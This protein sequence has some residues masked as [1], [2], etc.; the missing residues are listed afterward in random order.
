MNKGANTKGMT[1]LFSI[2]YAVL[3]LVS[4]ALLFSLN[5]TYIGIKPDILL[6]M[7]VVC[8]LFCTNKVSVALALVFGLLS[9]LSVTPP[10]HFSPVLFVLCAFFVPRLASVFSK[11]GTTEAAVCAIPFVFV[12]S[13]T[14]IFYLLSV[15]ENAKFVQMLTKCIVP[16][17]FCNI[18]CVI[19]LHYIIKLLVRWFRLD[20]RQYM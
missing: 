17:F 4:S 12:R 1:A 3:F 18:A 14:G 11:T 19:A 6:A 10:M 9:D 13:V 2:S 8:P 15:Y 5:E 16:E 20:Y 7:A